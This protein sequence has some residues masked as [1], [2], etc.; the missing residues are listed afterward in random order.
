MNHKTLDLH[1]HYSNQPIKTSLYCRWAHVFKQTFH[2]THQQRMT[3]D[4]RGFYM[5]DQTSASKHPSFRHQCVTVQPT[6]ANRSD[7]DKSLDWVYIKVY[8]RMSLVINKISNQVTFQSSNFV[9]QLSVLWGH[10]CRSSFVLYL[11]F[12]KAKCITL[13]HL[14]EIVTSTVWQI[15]VAM[16]HRRL[17]PGV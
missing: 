7:K 13:M 2:C 4:R 6:D 10:K 17:V 14:K 5:K 1:R 8:E 15:P 16:T 9:A 11:L 12:H 3:T